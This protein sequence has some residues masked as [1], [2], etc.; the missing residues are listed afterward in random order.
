MQV[1]FI[2]ENNLGFNG[3]KIKQSG[4]YKSL[5]RFCK[6][7]GYQSCIQRFENE[8]NKLESTNMDLS[9]HEGKNYP[10][11]LEEIKDDIY[12]S[13]K[14]LYDETI[15]KLF[16]RKK[17]DADVMISP[18]DYENEKLKQPIRFSVPGLHLTG[19][20]IADKWTNKLKYRTFPKLYNLEYRFKYSYFDIPLPETILDIKKRIFNSILE[21]NVQLANNSKHL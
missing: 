8:C 13:D 16:G 20:Y 9:I 19:N 4:Q 2:N 18:S 5:K 7:K 11:F 10:Q 6:E 12:I 1:Q 3:I 21:S 14:Q 17:Y 15:E